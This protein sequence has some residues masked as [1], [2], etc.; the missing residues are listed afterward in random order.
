MGGFWGSAT[1]CPGLPSIT[2]VSRLRGKPFEATVCSTLAKQ[3][4][5]QGACSVPKQLRGPVFSSWMIYFSP[6]PGDRVRA[7]LL[8]GF[9]Y[10]LTVKHICYSVN[11]YLLSPIWAPEFGLQVNLL[12]A[13]LLRLIC[14]V[15]ILS[16]L[17]YLKERSLGLVPAL[18]CAAEAGAH[19]REG[20]LG[21][22]TGESSF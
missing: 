12:K 20:R 17:R 9:G 4:S 14:L 2:E 21:T 5:A 16:S 15:F 1:G 19:P 18:P 22:E 3:M 10:H 6:L 8:L 13:N 11:K 7:V